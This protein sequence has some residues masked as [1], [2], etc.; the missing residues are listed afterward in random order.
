LALRIA[1]IK[2]V[3][4]V[5]ETT[6]NAARAQALKGIVAERGPGI[7]ITSDG[8]NARL[9]P[10]MDA[11]IE[12]LV[13]NLSEPHP[14]KK[15]LHM[16]KVSPKEVLSMFKAACKGSDLGMF[17]LYN[18]EEKKYNFCSS[19]FRKRWRKRLLH[20]LPKVHLRLHKG[21][22]SK[23]YSC[24]RINR[25]M[26]VMKSKADRDHWQEQKR[27]HL[28]FIYRER[29]LFNKLVH[30]GGTDP[31]KLVVI[32]DGW[33]S[34]KT[35]IPSYGELQGELEG[36][37]KWFLKTKLTGVLFVGYKLYMLRTFPWV[38]TGANLTVTAFMYALA[39]LQSFANIDKPGQ[40][41]STTHLPPQLHL[42]VDGGPEN[43]N[44]TMFGFAASLI[45]SNVFQQ[46][47]MSRLPVGHTHNQLDQCFQPPSVHFHGEG[48][49]DAITPA[50]FMVELGVAFSKESAAC[51]TE[52]DMAD[53][54]E[55][56]GFPHIADL[57]CTYDYAAEIV[58]S[59]DQFIG[60]HRAIRRVFE[61]RT[62]TDQRAVRVDTVMSTE[63]HVFDIYPDPEGKK[64]GYVS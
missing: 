16:D 49:V 15:E 41:S 51:V 25:R 8:R 34:C 29:V 54:H 60:G 44:K 31:D 4:Q 39:H 61:A 7:R 57:A 59:V 30:E 22:S 37:Y 9:A 52:V 55:R 50:A 18:S 1:L 11:Y 19:T 24:S 14:R 32:I 48:A 35:V 21:V 46:V 62:A 58:P 53:L 56:G 27:L 23:C 43:I 42:A 5:P 28:L 45:L 12:S 26:K 36:K 64:Q 40:E 20:G 63:L 3:L 38:Q 6:F 17:R 2:I 47:T 13:V 10:I 33:D